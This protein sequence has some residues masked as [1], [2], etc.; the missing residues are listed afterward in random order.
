MVGNP[1]FYPPDAILKLLWVVPALPLAAAVVNL[2]FARRLGRVAGVLAAGVMT[3]SFLAAAVFVLRLTDLPAEGRV[4]TR[5]LFDWITVGN[6]HVGTD[7]RLDSL[8]A[9]MILVVTG[10]GTLIH[11][12]AI[13][14]MHGDPRYGRFFAYLNLFVFFMLILVLADN[15]L[16]LY[17]G[18]EGVGL[19]SYLLIG[20]WFEK[21]ENANAAKKAF[22]TTRI[23]DTAM[24]VGLALIVVKLGTLDLGA[25]FGTGG[26]VL[27][28]GAA[29]AIALL[30]FAGAAGKSAQVPLHVWLPD[31]MAGPTPVSALI[32]AATMVTAG[33]YLVVRM[34]VIFEISGVALTVVLIVGLVTM[35]FA[36]TCALGQDDI[37][38]VLAYSTVSQLGYMFMAAGMRAYGVAIFM[39]VAHA[40]YKALMFLGAGSVM[41]GM[42]DEADMKQMGGL[43]RRM[44]LTGWA[45]VVGAV[46][47]AGVPFLAGFY[48]KDEILEIANS[49]G[50]PWVYALGSVGALLSAVYIGRLIFLTFFGS[51]RSEAAEHAHES[52]PVMTLPLVL[53]AIGA[54]AAGV[55]NTNPDGRIAT[56]L[57]PVVGPLSEGS[58]GLG[59]TLLIGIAIAIAALGLLVAWFVYASGK[60]DW[61][62]L[63]V[64]LA[65]VQ[66]LFANGWYLDSYYSA[67]LVTPGKAVAAFSAYVLDARLIDGIVNG[68]G[69][70]VHGL[71]NAARKVQTGFVRN[72]ALAFL[73]G[74]VGVLVYAGLR[75]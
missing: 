47:L 2:F 46:S 9:V 15:L 41:H 22:I 30:L 33:V 74:V 14:Y 54:A 18:W 16:L 11:V 6:L 35:L 19:C 58:A 4:V 71:A 68:V 43:I 34:H 20:F 28:K 70:A 32:H 37:K 60:I 3:A 21:T 66:R 53:L 65:P 69:G 56:F 1:H 57:E 39:L 27:T 42:H 26:S 63:R 64:R 12:Y 25:I 31:A 72:Y 38:R 23:G 36:A 5:H 50:R 51:P 8:S 17:L 13:G 67:I 59:T 73:V 24:L 45:F 40:F 62:A 44:P 10:V 49:S 7:L 75:F 55:L 52:P 48:A 29:T 61:V